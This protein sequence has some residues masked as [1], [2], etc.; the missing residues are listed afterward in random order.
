MTD[1]QK[2]LEHLLASRSKVVVADSP[3]K[4]DGEITNAT[5][6]AETIIN[7]RPVRVTIELTDMIVEATRTAARQFNDRIEKLKA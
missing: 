2:V 7:G 6:A 1:E 4:M 5:W 3:G